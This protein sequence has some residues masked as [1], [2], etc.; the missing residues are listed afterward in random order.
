[1]PRG[2]EEA[3]DLPVQTLVKDDAEAR[4]AARSLAETLDLD[5]QEDAAVRMAGNI[6][7]DDC[8]PVTGEGGRA[9]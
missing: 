1:M 2:A 6:V 5:R 7:Q 9:T 8:T 4:A 3:P